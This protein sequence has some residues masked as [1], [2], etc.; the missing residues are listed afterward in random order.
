MRSFNFA[1]ASRRRQIFQKAA[2]SIGD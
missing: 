1:S 2:T